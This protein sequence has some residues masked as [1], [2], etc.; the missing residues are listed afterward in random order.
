MALKLRAE[1]PL[2]SDDR[3]LLEAHSAGITLNSQ[4]IELKV[5]QSDFN[6]NN[7]ASLINQTATTI[8]IQASKIDLV[9][10]VTITD[11]STAGQT[12]INGSNITT[13][14]LN[15]NLIT[16]GKIT[17]VDIEG[18]NITGSLI[19]TSAG[20]SRIEL[21]STSLKSL[22]SG[23]KT[24]EI[25]YNSLQ[26]FSSAG[27]EVRMFAD[28]N[29]F[30][31]QKDIVNNR[32]AELSMKPVFDGSMNKI[33]ALTQL[34]VWNTLNG[35]EALLTLVNSSNGMTAEFGHSNSK[36]RFAQTQTYLTL[37]GV[38]YTVSR[39]SSDGALILT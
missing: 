21:D 25:D 12:T 15:A 39:R 34:R 24:I 37:N 19:K 23:I 6:G 17:A 28:L 18:V 38:E 29:G 14:A 2:V 13:G 11:L 8:K 31:A 22:S 9:G 26:I 33:G 35:G 7:I 3:N 32:Q 5:S 4:Q 27:R 30:F 36:L 16:T 20:T 10:Y 1:I